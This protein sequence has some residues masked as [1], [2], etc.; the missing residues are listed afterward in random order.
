[1]TATVH[2]GEPE[3][4]RSFSEGRKWLS[5]NDDKAWGERLYLWFIPVFFI[6]TG[7]SS[8]SGLGHTGNLW[9]FWLGVMVWLPYCVILPLWLRRG[10][11]LPFWKQWWFKFQIYM[12][13]IVFILSYF[14]T[15]YFF[16]VLGMR[17]HYSGVSWYLDSAL[18]GPDQASALAA[19]KRVPLGMYPLTMAF[20]TLY[21]CAAIVLVR[22]VVRAAGLGAGGRRMA[23]ALAMLAMACFF[24]FAE[25][26]LF[27]SAPS[28]TA[29]YED[30][31]TMLTIGTVFYSID[32]I[33]TFPS[34]YRLDE[35]R[36]RA[37][38]STSRIVIE[39]AAA[40]MGALLL[41]DF[42]ALAFGA[43]YA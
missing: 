17:Y 32:F 9:N 16:E 38:W 15:E 12:G 27:M 1:M 42:W 10:Q 40:A 36:T 37:P 20:F 25:T 22:R 18:L 3:E 7:I 21:H 23:Y 33:F 34:I 11:P 43:P 6:L 31:M 8:K 4:H 14:G 41:A 35:D 24:A 39:A 19:D 2:A 28:T 26:A 13:V 30:L 29:W 5:D